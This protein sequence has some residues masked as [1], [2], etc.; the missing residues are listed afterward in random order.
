MNVFSSVI[1]Q[2]LLNYLLEPWGFWSYHKG[3][4]RGTH[5]TY[6]KNCSTSM[7]PVFGLH[8]TFCLEKR[9]IWREG[10][11]VGNENVQT[12]LSRKQSMLLDS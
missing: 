3:Y 6:N 11:G 12:L 10:V 2:S 8:I 7:G 1:V 4:P 9:F 5:S